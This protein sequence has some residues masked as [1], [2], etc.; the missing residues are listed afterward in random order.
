ML[1][2]HIEAASRR[3]SEGQPVLHRAVSTKI[4]VCA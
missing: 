4:I 2:A 3:Q 1:A